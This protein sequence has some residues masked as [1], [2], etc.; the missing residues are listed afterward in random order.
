MRKSIVALVV[1]LIVAGNSPAAERRRPVRDALA[2][3]FPRVFAPRQTVVIVPQQMPA[4]T[5]KKV[6]VLPP[7]KAAGSGTTLPT[8]ARPV[9]SISSWSVVPAQYPAL[10]YTFAPGT[11][12]AGITSGCANGA[13][14]LK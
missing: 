14:R 10:T 1:M 3:A 6:E 13:C 12:H 9:A 5:P 8:G 2:N 7:P 11:A 4:A